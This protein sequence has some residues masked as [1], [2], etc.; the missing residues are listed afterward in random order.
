VAEIF[1]GSVSVGVVPDAKDF[2]NKLREQVVPGSDRI[3][4][5]IG[6]AIGRQ[7]QEAVRIYAE[8]VKE[9]LRHG[10]N[11]DVHADTT[12]AKEEIKKAKLETEAKS[13][14]VRLHVDNDSLRSMAAGIGAKLKAGLGNLAL[15]GVVGG[16]LAS[17]GS[18][19]LAGV[20]PLGA[21]GLGLGAF[22]AVAVPELTKVHDAMSK[23][24]TARKTALGNLTP[25][26]RQLI[27]AIHEI[28]SA[29]HDVVKELAPVVDNIV[30]LGA[31][32]LK[33]LMPTLGI[34]AHVGA[35]ILINFLK[36]FDKWIQSKSFQQLADQ[37]A[38][39]GDQ[40][41]KILGPQLVNLLKALAQLFVQL[42]P[43]GIRVLKLLI[44]FIIQFIQALAPGLVIL[45]GIAAAVLEWIN[46]NH[47]LIPVMI[48]VLAIIVIVAGPT[49]LGGIIAAILLVA[50]VVGFFAKHWKQIWQDIKN[51]AQD[52]WKFLTH[53][54]G[55]FLIPG[56]T[57]IRKVIEFVRDHWRDAWN[58]I[59]GVALAVW[60]FIH[61]QIV[62]PIVNFFTKTIPNAFRTFFNAGKQAWNDLKNAVLTVWHFIHDNIFSPLANFVTRT[63]PNAFTTAVGAIKKTW[64]TIEDI[65]STPVRFLV[66]T[67]YDN[68]IARLWNDVMG[69]IHGPKLPIVHFASGGRVPGWGG[70]DIVPALVERGETVVSKEHSSLLADVFRAVGVPGY[71]AGGVPVGRAAEL[72]MPQIKGFDN[73]FGFLG[74]LFHGAVDGGK[75][76]LALMSGNA[77]A[78]ANAFADLFHTPAAGD[79]AKMM[80]GIPKT[81]VSDAVHFVIKTIGSLVSH[82]GGGSGVQKYAGIVLQVLRMLG[83]PAGDLGVALAQMQTESGGDPLVVNK[84]DSN[85]AAGTPSVGLMQ[86]IGPTF[87]ANAGPFRGLGP[88]LYGVSVNPLANIYAGLHYAVG[89][90]GAGWT[91]VLGHGHGYD[92]GGWWPN[93]TIGI[94]TSGHPEYVLTH[95][96]MKHGLGGPTYHLHFD[97][98]SY[99]A[100]G[101]EVGHAMRVVDVH[102]GL[103]QRA[104]RRI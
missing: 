58:V 90:Y 47:L 77:T 68:G 51:W 65:F 80:I 42:L 81:I 24:G 52:A 25:Q 76:L 91:S 7:M 19:L 35:S 101:A 102:R 78:A 64:H 3:G 20:G 41:G 12:S 61:D 8:K 18:G 38:Q 49:G 103:S 5:E 69:A 93:N 23:V 22:A 43:S 79:L 11:V 50:L 95:D 48:A 2:H 4:D 83:Q 27:P 89:R 55:Q 99:R 98:M 104:G 97:G 15:G 72:G 34:F 87:A 67:V 16:G 33:H 73:P 31:G 1:V 30:K 75:I 86:V 66:N 13:W 36:P 21:A 29:F 39:F 74:K 46:K 6:R 96:D 62:A 32:V 45:A 70:G 54:W 71:Q 44:P 57:L 37:F 92:D 59:K 40:A 100:F 26:E 53:G 14:R 9:D 56:L 17:L 82:V 28:K 10:F 63:I 88:Y 60:H 94:N 84:W 85:W